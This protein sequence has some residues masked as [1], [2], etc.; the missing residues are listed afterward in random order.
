MK[1]LQKINNS[2][3]TDVKRPKQEL[4]ARDASNRSLQIQ[5]NVEHNL[6]ITAL[7][8]TNTPAVGIYWIVFF[9]ISVISFITYAVVIS[10]PTEPQI[11]KREVHKIYEK[12]EIHSR[13]P[14]ATS[15]SSAD[16][17]FEK[18]DARNKI[19]QRYALLRQNLYNEKSNLQEE[20]RRKDLNFYNSQAYLDLDS[21][22][23]KKQLMLR[24]QKAVELC[25][26]IKED[27]DRAEEFMAFKKNNPGL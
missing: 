17:Y 9:V 10:K 1:H 21:Y 18:S 23:D 26:I 27:C 7:K 6:E 5:P 12:V 20:G 13:A 15:T 14:A 25:E 3:Q 22:F 4:L 11:V 19:N 24:G 8:K 16:N 2:I